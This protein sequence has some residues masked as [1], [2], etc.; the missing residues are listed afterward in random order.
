MQAYSFAVGALGLT[1]NMA[2]I[3]AGQYLIMSVWA[4]GEAI[5]DMRDLYAGNKV[6][7]VKNEKK[8]EII[9]GKS[10]RYEV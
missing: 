4:Y 9:I 6:A 7:L 2:L 3:K 1:G 10:V 5:M 8:L